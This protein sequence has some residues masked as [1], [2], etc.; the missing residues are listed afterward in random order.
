MDE[1]MEG[2]GMEQLNGSGMEWNGW[3]GDECSE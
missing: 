2:K 3:N 1:R